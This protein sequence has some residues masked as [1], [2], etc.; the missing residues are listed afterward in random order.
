MPNGHLALPKNVLTAKMGLFWVVLAGKQGLRVG[1]KTPYFALFHI[2]VVFCVCK[3][4]SGKIFRRI[5]ASKK[6][7]AKKPTVGFCFCGLLVRW[8]HE[9]K[10]NSGSVQRSA[11]FQ[12]CRAAGF[13]TR[14]PQ[15]RE[16]DLE[17]GDPAG[18]ETCATDLDRVKAGQTWSN[19][20]EK[21]Y[22]A[23][24]LAGFSG[25]RSFHPASI[26]VRSGLDPA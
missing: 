17:V 23:R 14:R 12:V 21:I 26:P 15:F 3:L 20:N 10:K 4:L 25:R 16:A 18:L 13:P 2:L 7:R 5:R 9:Y 6:N 1:K 22:F 19:Q 24:T 8:L 11:D